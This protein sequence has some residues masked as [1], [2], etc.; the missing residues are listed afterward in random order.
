MLSAGTCTCI[1][2]EGDAA[3]EDP[4]PGGKDVHGVSPYAPSGHLHPFLAPKA[5]KVAEHLVEGFLLGE[6]IGHGHFLG[7]VGAC[8]TCQ[9]QVGLSHWVTG[10]AH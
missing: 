8:L 7:Q 4:R 5:V 3:I 9:L 6:D 1:C 10:F 2:G